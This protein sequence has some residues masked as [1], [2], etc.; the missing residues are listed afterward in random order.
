MMTKTDL[1]FA[2]YT[3][4]RRWTN[5]SLLMHRNFDGHI[6][7]MQQSG[8][9]W[10]K[11]Q[12]ASVLAQLYNL[13]P[14]AHIQD[15]SIIGHTKS[16]PKYKNIPQIVH[17]HGYP[18]GFTLMLPFLHYPKYLVLVRDLKESLVSHY[19]RFKGDYGNCDFAT[20]LRG[21]VRQKTFHSD[22]WSRMRFMNEWGRMLEKYPQSVMPLKYEDM[23]ADAGGSLRRVCQF[24]SIQNVTDAVIDS[25][26]AEASRD[27][28][29]EK[30]NPEVTTIV[31]R[32]EPRMDV[33][34][35]F[36][37]ENGAF[38]DATTARYLRHDFGYDLR[39]AQRK[40]AA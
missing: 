27:R 38:F 21:D 19:E 8:S 40:M 12:L 29:A 24:F 14:L 2:L 7:S 6:V 20:Y 16:P 39:G 1:I 25:A 18:H 13:P 30:P 33:A 11:N 37:G 17:S 10:I 5:G 34:A 36:N 22:I 35:Y 9:H 4:N 28:M 3:L 32:K 31:V 15:D 26:L 23:K